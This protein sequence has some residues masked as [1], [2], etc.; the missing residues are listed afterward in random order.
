MRIKGAWYGAMGRWR[1]KD[2]LEAE[3][4]NTGTV[5]GKRFIFRFQGGRMTLSGDSTYPDVGGLCDPLMP[6]VTFRLTEGDID[7]KTRMY[8]E[9][10]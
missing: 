4:R 5:S 8:W 9:P 7:T 3:I 10:N 2:K 1:A 6:E